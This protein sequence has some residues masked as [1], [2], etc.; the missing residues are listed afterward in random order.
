MVEVR[1]YSNVFKEY[2][3][4]LNNY[5]EQSEFSIDLSGKKPPVTDLRKLEKD[6]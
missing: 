2:H 6:Y 3:E 5:L 1:S 4:A